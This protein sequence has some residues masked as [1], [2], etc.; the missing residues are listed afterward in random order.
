[1][2]VSSECSLNYP[3][4][5]LYDFL[6]A[7]RGSGCTLLLCVHAAT[8]LCIAP[9]GRALTLSGQ[10]VQKPNEA[11]LCP[12]PDPSAEQGTPCPALSGA[13]LRV[14]CCTQPFA[15]SLR[16][17]QVRRAQSDVSWMLQLSC[18]VPSCVTTFRPDSFT[19]DIRVGSVR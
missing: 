19:L 5:L 2:G 8:G 10:A 18:G 4:R 13:M 11:P 15:P 14:P 3:P 7:P 1:M 17:C 9:L 6:G 12:L 16:F